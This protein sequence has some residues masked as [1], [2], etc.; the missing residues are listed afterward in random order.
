MFKEI[1]LL[2]EHLTHVTIYM[3][4]GHMKSDPPLAHCLL[5]LGSDPKLIMKSLQD[6]AILIGNFATNMRL[7]SMIFLVDQ[8]ANHW[9]NVYPF[10]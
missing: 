3:A 2:V 4:L 1:L 5:G 6:L 10:D 8:R 7:S 9:Q